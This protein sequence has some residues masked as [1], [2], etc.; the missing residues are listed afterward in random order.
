MSYSIAQCAHCL[1]LSLVLV[2]REKESKSHAIQQFAFCT[3][4][5][6]FKSSYKQINN[7]HCLIISFEYG[8]VLGKLKY[9]WQSKDL[10]SI[11]YQSNYNKTSIQWTL[12]SQIERS[13]QNKTSIPWTQGSWIY[14]SNMKIIVGQNDFWTK[15]CNFKGIG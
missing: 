1:E 15:T 14:L 10:V 2:P 5:L 8:Q 3:R 7:N 4:A 11:G 12:G 9:R 6:S 13:N